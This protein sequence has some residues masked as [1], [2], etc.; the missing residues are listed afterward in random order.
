LGSSQ[1]NYRELT[2]NFPNKA[3]VRTDRTPN[4]HVVA[5]ANHIL[6]GETSFILSE[7]L[8][9]AGTSQIMVDEIRSPQVAENATQMF[10]IDHVHSSSTDH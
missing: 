3:Q 6:D 8:N 5:D 4:V 1:D 9:D 7:L 2:L 10:S